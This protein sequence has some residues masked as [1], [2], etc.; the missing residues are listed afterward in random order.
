MLDETA[1]ARRVREIEQIQSKRGA[2]YAEIVP[3][4]DPCWHIIRTAPGEEKVA[5]A[6]LCSRRFGV[7]V[8][9]F[10]RE[11]KR[12]GVVIRRQYCLIPGHVFVF[13][14]GIA[15][16]WRRIKACPGVQSII[17][18]GEQPVVVASDVINK[19]QIIEFKE[20]AGIQRTINRRRRRHRREESGHQITISCRSFWNQA[21]KLDDDGRAALFTKALAL[22]NQA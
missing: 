22:E 10:T 20:D 2:Y 9:T 14:W 12:K 3:D 21:V 13:V 19:L 5:A 8:P 17:V 6:F 7:Y 1:N 4:V 18:R 16:H 15:A 11:H